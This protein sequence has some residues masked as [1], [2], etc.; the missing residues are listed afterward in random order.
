MRPKCETPVAS[1]IAPE[2]WSLAKIFVFGVCCVFSFWCHCNIPVLHCS[3]LHYSFYSSGNAARALVHMVV[4]VFREFLP[5]THHLLEGRQSK[6]G[7]Y[8]RSST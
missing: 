3:V 5:D 1:R 6:C 8:G 4:S 7:R 2:L